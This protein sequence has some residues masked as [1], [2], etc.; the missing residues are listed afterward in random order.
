MQAHTPESIDE[1]HSFLTDQCLTPMFTLPMQIIQHPRFL[2]PDNTSRLTV[3]LDGAHT[4]E[5]MISC[6]A[7]YAQATKQQQQ[8]DSQTADGHSSNNSSRQQKPVR[9]LIFNCMKERDP[10]MLL[11]QLHGE[12]QRQG[13]GIHVALFVPPDSQYAFLPSSSKQA[14]VE[15]AHQD[16]SWQKQLQAVWHQCESAGAAAGAEVQLP[17]LPDV[18]GVG[19]QD[20][21][22]GSAVLSS[23]RQALGWL[24]TAAAA[25]PAVEFELLVTGSLYLVGDCL[26]ALE[27]QPQ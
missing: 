15:A 17:R 11:P 22:S 19:V 6:A 7:W 27:Q 16:L 13:V 23:V 21:A 3:F 9:V 2:Q 24:E 10:A 8:Q 14:L 5:S 20:A 4:P 25:A 18:G 1:M 26:V 12:L